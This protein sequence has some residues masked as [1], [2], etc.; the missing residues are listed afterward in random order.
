MKTKWPLFLGIALLVAG[1]VMRK[2]TDYSLVGLAMILSGVALKTYYI[3]GKAR[4][5]EYRPGSELWFLF[6]GLALFFLGLYLK[7]RESVIEP[8]YL[9]LTGIALKVVFII[10][11]IRLT[12][13]PAK[14]IEQ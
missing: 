7:N 2:L 8:L 9:I 3:I 14:V 5:G 6:L 11:F 4:S 1:I 13:S 10:K 12:R